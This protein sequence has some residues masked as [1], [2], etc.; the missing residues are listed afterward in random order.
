M[1]VVVLVLLL[2][3]S[4]GLSEGGVRENRETSCLILA[5]LEPK[6]IFQV[7]NIQSGRFPETNE[8]NASC[9]DC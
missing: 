1:D 2:V 3:F 6:L 7:S 4:V 9:K 8:F 5:V